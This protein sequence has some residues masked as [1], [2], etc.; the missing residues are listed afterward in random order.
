MPLLLLWWLLFASEEDKDAIAGG[1]GCLVV[2]VVIAL[3][4]GAIGFGIYK[5]VS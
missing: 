5:V 4:V 1:M 2:F 3:I